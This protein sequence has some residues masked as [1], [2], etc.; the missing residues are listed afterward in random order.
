MRQLPTLVI[1]EL[2]Q[3]HKYC[4]IRS[5]LAATLDRLQLLVAVHV[6][7]GNRGKEVS[8]FLI[9]FTINSNA[10]TNIQGLRA[11]LNKSDTVATSSMSVSPVQWSRCTHFATPRPLPQT[12]VMTT[13][14]RY[15]HIYMHWWSRWTCGNNLFMFEPQNKYDC[16]KG[17]NQGEKR[18]W[19]RCCRCLGE[20]SSLRG[21]WKYFLHFPEQLCVC[22]TK[23]W[24]CIFVII[25]GS[26]WSSRKIS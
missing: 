25:L 4:T 6:A 12:A 13:P 5:I 20:A 8:N 7:S 16:G 26:T 11:S 17:I 14:F 10:N 9:R 21:G 3:Q 19:M 23:L 24:V 15:M 22:A 2:D 18:T 1:S